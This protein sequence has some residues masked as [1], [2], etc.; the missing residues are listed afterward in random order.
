MKQPDNPYRNKLMWCVNFDKQPNTHP[1]AQ[2][3]K[4]QSEYSS[5]IYSIMQLC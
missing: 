2:Y 4:K 3:M 5:K 1:A